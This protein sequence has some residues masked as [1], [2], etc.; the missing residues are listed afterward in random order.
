M[1]EAIRGYLRE[2]EPLK[3]V[4]ETN[5]IS[6]RLSIPLSTYAKLPVLDTIVHLFLCHIVR[7]DAHTLYAFFSKEER[8]LFETLLNLSGI[9]PKTAAGIVGHMDLDTFQRAI[10]SSDISSLSKLPGI[11]KKTAERLIVELRDKVEKKGILGEKAMQPLEKGVLQ[12]AVSALINLGYQSVD[13]QKAVQAVFKNNP[14]ASDLGRI[15]TSA[16]KM[17]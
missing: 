10:R 8:D 14:E 6:Y 4:V 7:E 13:A 3:A 9:G 17:V 12:D 15:I 1:Y 16:L 5:G 2:K 11:G